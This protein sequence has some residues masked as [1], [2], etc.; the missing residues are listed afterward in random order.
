MAV[1]PNMVERWFRD[2]TDKAIRR[3][4]FHSVNEL[5][6]AIED[7]LK[8]NN[9]NPNHSCGPPPPSRSSP[10]SPADES[11]SN[12]CKINNETLR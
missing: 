1:E 12:K 7:Y 4:V 3:G 10:R 5:I 8:V 11:R 6:T 2:L 9:D